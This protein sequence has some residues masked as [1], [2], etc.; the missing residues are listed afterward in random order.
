MGPASPGTASGCAA[1]E[2]LSARHRA[3]MDKRIGWNFDSSQHA[4]FN[5]PRPIA[6]RRGQSVLRRTHSKTYSQFRSSRARFLD[7]NRIIGGPAINMRIFHRRFVLRAGVVALFLIFLWAIAIGPEPPA[8]VM[9]SPDEL[10]RA[11]TIQRDSLVDLCLM[12]RVDPNGRDGQGRTPLLIATSQQQ[13]K[14]A[15]R[16][17]DARAAVALADKNGF[18]PLMAA[19]THGDLE[20]FQVLLARPN[21]IHPEKPCADGQDLL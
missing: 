12:E 16:L 11:V 14:T 3:K 10:V 1:N 20:M 4:T 21:N 5:P 8:R 6:V 15:R 7:E 18:T 2:L 9:I 13:W 17:L 19:A